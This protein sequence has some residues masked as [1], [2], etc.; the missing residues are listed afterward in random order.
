M[1]DKLT[2]FGI[3]PRLEEARVKVEKEEKKKTKEEAEAALTKAKAS[4]ETAGEPEILM[5]TV[6]TKAALDKAHKELEEAKAKFESAED[7]SKMDE[8]GGLLETVEEAEQ[9][10]A[11]LEEKC[12]V[13]GEVVTHALFPKTLSTRICLCKDGETY[14]GE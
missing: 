1:W 14:K 6:E 4:L 12:N 13:E 3:D 11:E 5:S 8:I 9:I 7:A 10:R 2:D